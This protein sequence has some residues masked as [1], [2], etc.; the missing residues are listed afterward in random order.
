MLR[1]VWAS[2]QMRGLWSREI[3]SS[4][5]SVCTLTNI[6]CV[7]WVAMTDP[8]SGNPGRLISGFAK[9]WRGLCERCAV[10]VEGGSGGKR[11]GS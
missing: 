6:S 2:E 7:D 3:S 4:R 5:V 11:S 9:Q 10:K 1:R 8:A